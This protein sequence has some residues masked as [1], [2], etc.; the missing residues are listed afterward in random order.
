MEQEHKDKKNEKFWAAVAY[1]FFP[2]PM[3]L[4]KH[5]SAFLNY[6]INQGIILMIVSIS[7]LFGS[8]LLPFSSLLMYVSRILT[9]I[10]LIIGVVN[11]FEGKTKPLPI[12]GDSF[13]FIK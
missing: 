1:F 7:L 12:I 11:V 13:H 10:G 3:I 5:R 2:L 9:M 6:H 4:V 8:S